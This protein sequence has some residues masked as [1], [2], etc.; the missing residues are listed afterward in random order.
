[1]WILAF[2]D[3]INS[4]KDI[5]EISKIDI[6]MLMESS[7]LLCEKNLIKEVTEP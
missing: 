5:E 6:N 2:S 3:G 4:I 1:M 7:K